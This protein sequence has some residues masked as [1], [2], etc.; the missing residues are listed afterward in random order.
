VRMPGQTKVV[1]ALRYHLCWA[2]GVYVAGVDGFGASTG[3]RLVGCFEEDITG[4][5][6]VEAVADGHLDRRL[7]VQVTARYIR[8]QLRDLG[9]DS[10]SG[11]FSRRGIPEN[12]ASTRLRELERRAEDARQQ[13]ESDQPLVM[14]A[15]IVAEARNT[16]GVLSG[17]SFQVD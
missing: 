15:H 16:G 10:A 7:D 3:S 2:N 17:H 9:T 14:V 1:Q 13:S 11:D 6:H 8:A 12:G 5:P 4:H